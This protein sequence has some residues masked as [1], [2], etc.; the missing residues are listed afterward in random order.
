MSIMF[1]APVEVAY[2][3]RRLVSGAPKVVDLA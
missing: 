3:L 2:S 1:L